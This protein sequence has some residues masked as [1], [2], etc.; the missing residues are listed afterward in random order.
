MASPAMHHPSPSVSLGLSYL[1][2]SSR[3]NVLWPGDRR[4]GS[5]WNIVP[6]R[7]VIAAT[8]P[9]LRHVAD[10]GDCTDATEL[11]RGFGQD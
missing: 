8:T 10:G 6:A 3:V 5:Q 9:G 2:A 11:P 4:V 7:R 1:S